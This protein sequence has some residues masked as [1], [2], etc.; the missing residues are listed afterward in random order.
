[1]FK[2]AKKEDIKEIEENLEDEELE[3]LPHFEPEEIEEEKEEK[4]TPVDV[5]EKLFKEKEE[6]FRKLKA[7]AQILIKKAEECRR[8]L[9]VIEKAK[10]IK[11]PLPDIFNLLEEIRD[12][13]RQDLSDDV[14]DE[15]QQ[16]LLKYAEKL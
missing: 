8:Q 6:E 5:I 12:T 13:Y 10:K 15:L 16:K 7:E 11:I 2:K 9:Q 1:M 4:E 14:I 3:N